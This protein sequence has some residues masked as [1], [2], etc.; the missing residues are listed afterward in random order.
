MRASW[1]VVGLG[2]CGL[3]ALLWGPLQSSAPRVL[4]TV[5]VQP[6]PAGS[7]ALSVPTGVRLA[8]QHTPDPKEK[9]KPPKA[10][11]GQGHQGQRNGNKPSKAAICHRTGSAEHPSRTIAPSERAWKAHEGHGDTR[12]ACPS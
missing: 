12:G 3:G 10:A 9:P 4:A 7:P 2:V 6:L 8:V 1:L 11:S 5:P